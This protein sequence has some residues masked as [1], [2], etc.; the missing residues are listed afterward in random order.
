[1]NQPLIS[2]IM[3][4]LNGQRFIA[5]AISSI[6]AQR[7]SNLEII[8]IDDGS[9]D[10]SAE[11]AVQM[12]ARVLK[13]TQNTGIA[14]ARNC[15][16]AAARGELI[17]FLDADDLWVQ[18]KL[19]WQ[20][21]ALEKHPDLMAV[22]G[23]VER[24]FGVSER[25]PITIKTFLPVVGAVL[26]RRE[27]F[28]QIGGFDPTMTQSEDFDWFLRLR[29]QSLGFA[30]LSQIVL[31]YRSHDSNITADQNAV[32]YWALQAIHKRSQRRQQH[33]TALPEVPILEE[34]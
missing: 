10:S 33:L 28:E 20:L 32:R 13:Q 12:G 4:V 17:A 14:T 9:T 15:G 16:L 23:F 24:F 3:P 1:M 19:E 5:E 2:V 34:T 25:E 22:S 29:E 31:R 8:V 18:N 27:V 7:Y 26:V 30:M 6:E 11:I 21:K